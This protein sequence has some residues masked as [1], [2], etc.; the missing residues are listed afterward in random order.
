MCSSV[1]LFSCS[2]NFNLFHLLDDGGRRWGSGIVHDRADCTVS[3]CSNLSLIPGVSNKFSVI[4]VMFCSPSFF[5]FLPHSLSLCLTRTDYLFVSLSLK[6]WDPVSVWK[7]CKASICL[8]ILSTSKHTHTHIHKKKTKIQPCTYILPSWN[9]PVGSYPKHSCDFFV[10]NTISGV[11][12]LFFCYVV[13]VTPCATAKGLPVI[14]R[15]DKTLL[16]ISFF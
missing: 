4:A 14:M 8:P 13:W 2:V 12:F 3:F 6:W 11:L 15:Q 9:I 16:K 1:K 7:C 5:L 10:K